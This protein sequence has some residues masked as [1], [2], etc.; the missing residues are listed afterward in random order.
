VAFSLQVNYNDWATVTGQQI[1][2]PTFADR[3]AS[4]G[5]HDGTPT[6]VNLRFL[7]WNRYFF[8][9]VAPHLYSQG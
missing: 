3:V 1:L 8:F 5:Q 4:H 2:V 7:D 9:L 6:A